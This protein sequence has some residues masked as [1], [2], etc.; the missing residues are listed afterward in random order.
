MADSTRAFPTDSDVAIP[1][2]SIA[3]RA[4]AKAYGSQPPMWRPLTRHTDRTHF[5]RKRRARRAKGRRIE[6]RQRMPQRMT[7]AQWAANYRIP[8]EGLADV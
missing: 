3:Q 4:F 8:W 1:L 5:G 2:A 7:V 6:A